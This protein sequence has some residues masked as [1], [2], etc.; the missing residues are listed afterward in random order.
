MENRMKNRPNLGDGPRDLWGGGIESV[1]KSEED[2]D[3]DS[4]EV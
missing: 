4:D 1:N 2:G 3:E